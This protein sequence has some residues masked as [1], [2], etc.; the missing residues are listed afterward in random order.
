[1]SKIKFC[2]K[3]QNNM[4]NFQIDYD[5]DDQ[6]HLYYTC[7]ACQYQEEKTDI[8]QENDAILHHKVNFEQKKD[9]RII[10]ECREDPTLPFQMKVCPNPECPSDGKLVETSYM[11]YSQ[12]GKLV[13][14][15]SKCPWILKIN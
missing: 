6:Y 2:P 15:C 7:N 9:R 14:F 1:M 4:N 5:Q 10:S 11:E 13:F 12:D 8:N 3:C